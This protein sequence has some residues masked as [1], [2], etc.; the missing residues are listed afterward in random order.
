MN[1]KAYFQYVFAIH[2]F[3]YIYFYAAFWLES[4]LCCL[5]LCR[6]IQAF[7]FFEDF[8]LGSMDQYQKIE[9]AMALS[10]FISTLIHGCEVGEGTYGVVYKAQAWLRLHEDL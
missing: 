6:R 7:F 9:K 4:S 8:L 2:V 10:D 3:L 5:S 1:V